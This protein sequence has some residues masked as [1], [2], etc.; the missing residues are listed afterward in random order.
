MFTHAPAE[1]VNKLEELVPGFAEEKHKYA[2]AT[3]LWMSTD[4]SRQHRIYPSSITLRCHI[5]ETGNESWR[6]KQSQANNQQ[7]KKS[8]MKGIKN[9]NQ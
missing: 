1:L 7:L 3:M 8:K 4:M 2:I 6:F 9:A 5:V